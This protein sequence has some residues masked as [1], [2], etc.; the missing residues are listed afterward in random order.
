MILPGQAPLTRYGFQHWIHA[1]WPLHL[2]EAMFVKY[3][4]IVNR[5]GNEDKGDDKG[6]DE[7]PIT[8]K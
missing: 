1:K 8:I 7:D 2:L 4:A 3:T 5:E 6:D